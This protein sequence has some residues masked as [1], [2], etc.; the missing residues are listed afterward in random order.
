LNRRAG[1]SINQLD[2][3]SSF[4]FLLTGASGPQ[5]KPRIRA[6]ESLTNSLSFFPF[7]SL[8]SQLEKLDFVAVTPDINHSRIIWVPIRCG[9][10]RV[11]M[12]LICMVRAA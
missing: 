1:A 7:F 9:N 8:F 11:L 6:Q 10:Q 5:K 2:F 12:A 3:L 4:P